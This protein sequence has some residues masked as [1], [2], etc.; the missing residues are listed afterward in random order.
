MK[1]SFAAACLLCLLLSSCSTVG[2]KIDPNQLASVKPGVTTREDVHR[3][4]GAPSR[5]ET[6]SD[7]TVT[8]SYAYVR[9]RVK[10][11]SFIPVAGAFVG[12]TRVNETTTVFVYNPDGTVKEYSQG[13]SNTESTGF[14]VEQTA[15]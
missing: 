14:R 8:E 10:G 13:G 9:A 6:R 7:G 4:F 5:R 11:Q 3:I 2:H 15:Q 1:E 12:G